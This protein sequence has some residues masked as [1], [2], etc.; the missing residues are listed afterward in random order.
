M[1]SL[2][3]MIALL[4]GTAAAPALAQ[5]R[6]ENRRAERSEAREQAREARREARRAERDSSETS[7]A[8]EAPRPERAPR[9]IEAPASAD[10]GTTEAPRPI[11]RRG[12]DAPRIRREA[13]D[14][15]REWRQRERYRPDSPSAVQ[16]ANT[17]PA[18]D[19][20]AETAVPAMD[21]R[22]RLIG[23]NIRTAPGGR[24]GRVLDR[25]VP[26]TPGIG[27]RRL[28]RIGGNIPAEGTAPPPPDRVAAE[29]G[30]TNH[31]WSTDWRRD[32]RYDWRR[33]RDRDRSRF[34]IGFYF[35]PFG[36]NYRRYGV[37]WRLWP[38]Y[39]S[40]DYWLSDPWYYRLPPAYGPYRWIRYHDDALLVN[41][42]TGE[43]VDVI[44]DFFW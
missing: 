36:W 29:R 4:A 6:G 12:N 8:S 9:R 27:D 44:Y 14:T 25:R 23:D 3:M 40:H 28:G 2:M 37:G 33:H 18:L 34:H 5:E 11:K 38:S 7:S 22:R 24:P 1:R 20:P 26:T 15:V 41:I 42:Y 43:V 19:T 21:R 10:G 16:E 17:A 30:R 35:D 39:Y 31:R 32:R 13:G